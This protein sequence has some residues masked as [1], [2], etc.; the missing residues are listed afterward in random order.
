MIGPSFLH[1]SRWLSLAL[2]VS[3]I[4]GCGGRTSGVGASGSNVAVSTHGGRRLAVVLGRRLRQVAAERHSKQRRLTILPIRGRL[5]YVS[6]A[7]T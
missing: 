1:G 7:Q 6:S 5:K 2:G 4:A 3:A